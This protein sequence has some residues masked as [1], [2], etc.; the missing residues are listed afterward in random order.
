MYW[1]TTIKDTIQWFHFLTIME[2]TAN[3]LNPNK[4][5][6]TSLL[7]VLA[8]FELRLIDDKDKSD[9]IYIRCINFKKATGLFLRNSTFEE[10]ITK[11]V[12]NTI[13]HHVGMS[14]II[15]PNK[16]MK[17][18]IDENNHQDWLNKSP[19]YNTSICLKL[20]R[21]IFEYFI[22]H[23]RTDRYNL[24]CSLVKHDKIKPAYEDDISSIG[25]RSILKNETTKALKLL[26]A[27][28]NFIDIWLKLF[29]E[30]YDARCVAY[31]NAM[32]EIFKQIL[33]PI[34]KALTPKQKVQKLMT[35]IGGG[36][37]MEK[38]AKGLPPLSRTKLSKKSQERQDEIQKKLYEAN[39]LW[40]D[41]KFQLHW[42]K[43]EWVNTRREIKRKNPIPF[44]E[45]IFT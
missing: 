16:E 7:K 33:Q 37:Y 40:N 18:K 15:R 30:N 32:K 35:D 10:M 25:D 38:S 39:K 1:P 4:G 43:L 31:I 42:H 24:M 22:T 9:A 6:I 19:W 11:F 17:Y 8:M 26:G 20:H 28:L 14:W 13:L 44:L 12:L 41:W 2:Q 29:V 23:A 36:W 3:I 21:S 27:T 34:S 45:T 5:I